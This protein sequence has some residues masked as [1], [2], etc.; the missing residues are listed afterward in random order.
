[1]EH[2]RYIRTI[3]KKNARGSGSAGKQDKYKIT[4]IVQ[5]CLQ[6]RLALWFG[7]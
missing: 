6:S 3:D 7:V 1:M 2:K 5:Q 4:K